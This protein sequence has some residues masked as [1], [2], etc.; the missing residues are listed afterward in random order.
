MQR[1]ILIVDDQS[2]NINAVLIIL[3]TILKLDTFRTCSI[4]YNGLEAL[5]K[6]KQSVQ[7]YQG[8]NCGFDLILMDC[9]MPFMDGYDS[10]QEIR[11]YLYSLGIDQPLIVALTGHT[12]PGFIKRAIKAGMNQ[13]LSKP[14]NSELLTKLIQKLNIE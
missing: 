2:F 13:V 8:Q 7:A 4:A 14:V 1:R 5:E 3:N 10:T 12:E 6:V 11:K 9:N